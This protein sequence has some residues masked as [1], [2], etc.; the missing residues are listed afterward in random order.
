MDLC[1][2]VQ[3]GP[4]K[5]AGRSPSG[6]QPPPVSQWST[7]R[8]WTMACRNQEDVRGMWTFKSVRRP[9]PRLPSLLLM[10]GVL[11]P[12]LSCPQH[13]TTPRPPLPQQLQQLH[14]RPP[15]HRRPPSTL[16]T[17]DPLSPLQKE[18]RSHN[19]L[20]LQPCSRAA[21]AT[22]RARSRSGA[23]TTARSMAT[24]RIA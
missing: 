5:M 13:V 8:S 11:S 17:L 2:Q 3:T 10:H 6:A 23:W 15:A 16:G 20:V 24:T 4:E 7:W 9:A 22:A 12:L 19:V 21:W 18:L 14:L 1:H